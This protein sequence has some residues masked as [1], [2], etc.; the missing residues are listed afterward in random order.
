MKPASTNAE[1]GDRE[2]EGRKGGAV[3]DQAK[4]PM[5]VGQELPPTLI[6]AHSCVTRLQA[7][8]S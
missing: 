1:H 5:G 2:D 7:R 8:V 4:I 6:A 3:S